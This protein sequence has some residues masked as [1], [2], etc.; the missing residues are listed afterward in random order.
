MDDGSIPLSQRGK[1]FMRFLKKE[2]TAV[3]EEEIQNEIKSMVD[4][5]HEQGLFKESEAEMIKNIFDLDETEA[6]DIMTHRKHIVSVSADMIFRDFLIFITEEGF[7]RYPVY[8]DVPD[9][10]VGVIHIKDVLRYVL[11]QDVMK[12]TLGDIPELVLPVPFVPEKRNIDILFRNMQSAKTHMVIVVDEYG[13]ISGL[14]TME[15]ILEE[16]VGNIFDEHDR[17]E[18]SIQLQKDGSFLISGMA[19]LEEVFETLGVEDEDSLEDFDT[20]NGYIISRIDRIPSDGETFCI[21]GYG[22][23]FEVLSVR[24]KMI[25][26]VHVTKELPRQNND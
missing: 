14:I 11:R 24:D 8:R 13:Q 4:E 16:I 18:K 20:L 1:G 15:D 26:S 2:K 3:Q 25:E 19:E 21:A 12:L 17:E 5:G 9:N 22:Y 7:S 23:Q 6:Q 10:I